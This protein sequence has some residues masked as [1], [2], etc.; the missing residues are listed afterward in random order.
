MLVMQ[1]IGFVMI[2]CSGLLAGERMARRYRAR[3]SDLCALRHSL[4]L[5][6]TYVSHTSQPIP[7]ALESVGRSIRGRTGYL[8]CRLSQVL[9]GDPRL[10]LLQAWDFIWT[11]ID[12]NGDSQLPVL[13][14]SD[15]DI[16]G[17]LFACLGGSGRRDQISHIRL[18]SESLAMNEQAARRDLDTYPR[19]WRYLGALGAAVLGLAVL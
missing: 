2:F 13:S 1:V 11:E 15:L 14:P 19:L 18:A 9:A 6:E 12:R 3:Y 17:R 5:L 7:R 10:T 16:L 4:V 8:L